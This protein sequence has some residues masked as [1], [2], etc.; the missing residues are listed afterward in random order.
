[1]TVLRWI[2][3]VLLGAAL[4]ACTETGPAGAQGAAIV[5]RVPAGAA[6]AVFAGG[7]FWCTEVDFE[8]LP[9]V[10]EAVSGYTGGV[11]D[12]PTYREVTSGATGHY[13]AVRVFYDAEMVSY[14]TLVRY[15]VLTIDVTDD[16]GQ[17]CDRG[18]SYRPAIFVTTLQERQ[19]AD[20][21]LRALAEDHGLD[22]VRVRVLDEAAFFD[23][24][25]YHQDYARREALAYRSYRLGCGRDARLRNLYGDAAGGKAFLQ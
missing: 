13:E 19:S 16:G 5:K 15:F 25:A 2:A 4:M 22:G 23:A 24:E 8:K 1:M 7:C 11:T 20:A 14:D 9:G 17:F 10:Y 18:D 3:I 21:A 6:D 12:S